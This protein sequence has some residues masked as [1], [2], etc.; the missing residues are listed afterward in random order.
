MWTYPRPSCPDH[1]SSEELSAAKVEARIHKVL[2]HRVNSTPSAD[3]V[4]LRRGIASVRVSNLGPFLATFMILSFHCAH[5]LAHSLGGSHSEPWD[6][7]PPTDVVGQEVRH[8][9]SEET[10][11]R[12]ERD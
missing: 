10:W 4:P 6:A 8:A 1:P 12:E 3:P 7:D 5:D 11:A 9:S 2:D